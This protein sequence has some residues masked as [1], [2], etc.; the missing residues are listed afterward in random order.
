MDMQFNYNGDPIGGVITDYLLEKVWGAP[1]VVYLSIMS[2]NP[3]P[4]PIVK[5]G[6]S[7]RRRAQLP[8][9]LPASHW[10]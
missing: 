1:C 9:V 8:R 10:R 6:T 4:F 5:G 2:L 7:A 3:C